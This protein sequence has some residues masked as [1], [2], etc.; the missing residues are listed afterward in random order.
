MSRQ[1]RDASWRWAVGW[2][3]L[4]TAMQWACL[5]STS[6]VMFALTECR[7]SK[8]TTVP[9]RSSGASSGWKCVVSFV[10]APTSVWA[11][12]TTV[13]WVTAESRCRRGASRRDYPL[14]ALP[15]T[16]ITAARLG[17]VVRVPVAV[18]CRS[19]R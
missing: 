9:A 15:S 1:G 12:V 19:A 13:P 16:A 14:S 8:V 3:V 11:R 6:Q 5:A 7:A 4:I 17:L 18:R 2:L 10:F